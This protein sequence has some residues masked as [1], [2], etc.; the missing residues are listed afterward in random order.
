MIKRRSGLA[1]DRRAYGC[2][3]S[4]FTAPTIGVVNG[5]GSPYTSNLTQ[6]VLPGAIYDAGG[7][8][9]PNTL[10]DGNVPI[11]MG[12]IPFYFFG[13]NYSNS[14]YWTSNNAIIFGT[15]SSMTI[16]L[17]VDIYRNLIPSILL[18]NYDRLL[19]SFYYSNTA[20][21]NHS[22][23]TLLVT[24][25]DYYTAQNTDPTYQYKIRLIKQNTGAQNQYVEVYVIS[26]PPSPGYSSAAISYPSGTQGGNP[27]DS[28]G[29]TI[30]ATKNSPY[31]I[32]NGTSFLNLC[33]STFSLA[34]PV[35]NTSF[36]FSSDS[37]GSTWSFTN[38]AHVNV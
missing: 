8:A 16:H 6:V 31:N 1:N 13:T 34:S 9:I 10:D 28:N 33:G 36:V 22:I 32:S 15:A 21:A 29:N 2:D 38:N 20:T 18:G 4:A 30:D 7:S 14:M 12:N 35:A 19:K 26:S 11:P 23:T 25:Y 27:I 5:P 3:C 37:T 17:E 24:F